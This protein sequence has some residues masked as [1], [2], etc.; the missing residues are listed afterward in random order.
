MDAVSPELALVCP[1]LRERALALL[2][3]R[4]PDGW[5]PRRLVLAAPPPP[6]QRTY[7]LVVAAGAY[8]LG[9]SARVALLG[10][11]VAATLAALTVVAEAAAR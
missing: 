3:E 9:S 5:I 10:V 8:A 4:D 11:K 2:P 7:P 1:E 6:E